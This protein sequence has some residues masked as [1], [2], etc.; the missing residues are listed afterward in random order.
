M[1]TEQTAP[2]NITICSSLKDDAWRDLDGTSAFESWHFDAISDD[3]CEALVVAFYDNYALSPRFHQST[4]HIEKR[5]HPAV[6]F[7]YSVDGKVVLSSVNEY[8]HRDFRASCDIPECRIGESSFEVRI[9]DYGS[10]F[11]VSIDIQALGGRLIK[12]ELEWLLI[13]ADMMPMDGEPADA[14]WD[15]VAP[16]ADVSGRISL[17]GRR[18][19][20]RK[21]IHFR[22]TGYHD[23]ISS[24]NVHYRDLA[25]RMWGR[26]H[27]VDSTVV[28]ERHGGVQ[29]RSAPGTFFLIRDGKIEMRKAA[30]EAS[31]FKRDRWGLMLPHQICF[32]SDDAIKICVTPMSVIRSGFSDVKTLSRIDL[33]L[34][35]GR[36]REANGITEFIDPR[37]LSGKITKWISDLRI[38]QHGRPPLF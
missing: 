21:E 5:R 15:L 34:G 17:I 9:A 20:I 19:K 3:G 11:A 38:G 18:G 16:R 31:E 25:S 1:L 14:V 10:G 6:S 23:H 22:G 7:V 4:L 33:D 29:N 36:T 32:A 37:R 28:F 35:D 8:L 13:E 24:N 30:C 12:A 26:A 2:S 27:F